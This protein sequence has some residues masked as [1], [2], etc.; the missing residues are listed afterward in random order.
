MTNTQ[1]MTNVDYILL[2]MIVLL[3]L[4]CWSFIRQ[5]VSAEKQ[6]ENWRQQYFKTRNEAQEL[7]EQ[8]I[9]LRTQLKQK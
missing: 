9:E 8:N 7:F 6:A 4:M 2:V 1:E 5:L 3:M